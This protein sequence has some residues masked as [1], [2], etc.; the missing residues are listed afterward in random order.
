MPTPLSSPRL[1][2][3][4]LLMASLLALLGVVTLSAFGPLISAEKAVQ[5]DAVDDEVRVYFCTSCGYRQNFEQV[6]SFLED[7]YPHLVDRVYGANYDAD[8][9]KLFAAQMIGYAQLA[10]MALMIFGET[11]FR[12]MGWDDTLLQKALN[13]RIACFAVILFMGSLSQSMVSTGAFEIFYNGE[14]VFSKLQ[15]GRWPALEELTQLLEAR[16][17]DAI[18]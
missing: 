4:S 8:P 15:L 16:G 5:R 17:I 2:R 11:L 12:S 18:Y 10:A 13:N 9:L 6:K 1:S 7:K 3:S 14:L